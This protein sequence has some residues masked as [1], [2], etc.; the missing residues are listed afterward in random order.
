M[1]AAGTVTGL[2]GEPLR[3][4]HPANTRPSVLPDPREGA[5]A[6]ARNHIHGSSVRCGGS[7]NEDKL[8]QESIKPPAL[9]RK[10]RHPSYP[11]IC[12]LTPMHPFL[13]R[14][15]SH[16]GS[17]AAR[18]CATTRSAAHPPSSLPRGPGHRRPFR[19][20]C[21][22]HRASLRAGRGLPPPQNSN[23]CAMGPNLATTAAPPPPPGTRR[24]S[25]NQRTSASAA[26]GRR[27]LRD[28]PRPPPA[29]SNSPKAAA[30]PGPRVCAGAAARTAPGRRAGPRAW[31]AS[32][33]PNPAPPRPSGVAA[34]VRAAR[35]RPAR[36]AYFLPRPCHQP[37]ESA[38]KGARAQEETAGRSPGGAAGGA[39]QTSCAGRAT[40]AAAVPRCMGGS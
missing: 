14:S 38:K 22:A 34:P 6:A 19:R 4:A 2:Y 27:P 20:R 40:L 18:P 8:C 26:T 1:A 15:A 24:V 16:R 32:A 11:K 25:A 31:A 39:A 7:T 37:N 9:P 12:H 5:A 36:T 17:F 35:P 28:S 3:Q 21:A 10:V 23:W 29:P 30:L 13:N 33:R